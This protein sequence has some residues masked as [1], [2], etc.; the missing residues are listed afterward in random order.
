MNAKKTSFRHNPYVQT[1]FLI[2]GSGIAGLSLALKLSELGEVVILTKKGVTSGSTG[3]AQGGI[4]G[5]TNPEKDSPENHF[6][7]TMKAGAH[8]NDENAVKLLVENG[9]KALKDLQKWGVEFDFS[10]H[11]EGGHTYAR[12]F[13]VA[14]ETGRVVQ[15][16]LSDEVVKNK[17]IKLVENAFAT[18]L[19]AENGHVC[20]IYFFQ[21]GKNS[22]CFAKCTILATGGAGQAYEKTTNPSIITG[23]GMAI[24]ARAGAELKDMEFV[25]FHPTTLDMP[26]DPLFLLSEALRG[27]GAKIVDE[28]ENQFVDE[29][30]ARDIVAR[31]IFENLSQ[32]KKVFLDFRQ[33]AERKLEK[34]FPMIFENLLSFGFNLAHDLIPISL[35][36]HFLCGGVATDLHGKTSLQNLFAL[37][38]TACTGVHGANR[39]ASNSLLE[40]V[41]F[42]DQIY[43]YC[44]KNMTEVMTTSSCANSAEINF[45]SETKKDQ[46]IRQQIQ[47]T[48]QL[49]VGVVRNQ[50][51]MKLALKKLHHLHPK[52]TEVKNLL[53]VATEITKAA[54]QRKK[55][56][57]C[58][59]II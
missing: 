31:S 1:D 46:E 43:R 58:H 44:K 51:G 32:G 2:I 41:V 37:G 13:H 10:L 50:N 23:D 33:R 39:L 34:E 27:A 29:L 53:L 48:M 15:E 24:A 40:G 20:G 55:S 4:A 59:V 54:L 52:G 21:N 3:L 9:E 25:Q 22:S 8:H 5:V 45:V 49:S 28:D 42:A 36:A 12:V 35:A 16:I 11:R 56:L 19:I 30:A 57:G 18:D 17:K 6:R 7:D 47:S 26:R 14:D 38:E